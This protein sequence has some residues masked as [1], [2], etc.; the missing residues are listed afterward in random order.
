MNKNILLTVI[1]A[2]TCLLAGFLYTH[3]RSNSLIASESASLGMANA[4]HSAEKWHNTKIETAS[5]LTQTARPSPASQK[6][7]ASLLSKISRTRQ[8]IPQ[9]TLDQAQELHASGDAIF[10][11]TRG[12]AAYE[13]GRIKGSVSMPA[14]DM[15]ELLPKL[16]PFFREKL[17]IT[18][19][20]GGG[21]KLSETTAHNLLD[22]GFERLAIFFGG[23]ESWS[24]AGLPVESGKPH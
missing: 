11:D 8:E 2:I 22:N 13:Q 15:P 7:Y 19:C 18:Y 10:I 6:N 16:R 17:L 1:I 4:G 24:K 12:I 21:C 9:I 3:I 20:D 23:W 5:I 14:N